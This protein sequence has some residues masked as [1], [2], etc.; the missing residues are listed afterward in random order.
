[1]TEDIVVLS[2]LFY[3]ERRGKNRLAVREKDVE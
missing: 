1:V 3:D 2:S